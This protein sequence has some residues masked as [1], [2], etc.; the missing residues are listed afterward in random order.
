VRARAA[1]ALGGIPT[2]QARALLQGQLQDGNPPAVRA[3]ALE[4][5]GKQTLDGGE[6]AALTRFTAPEEPLTVR[7][8]AIAALAAQK[9]AH[10]EVEGTLKGF[11][12]KQA[13]GSP[14]KSLCERS[15]SSRLEENR[16]ETH[17]HGLSDPWPKRP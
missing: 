5:L 12:C 8:S 11:S 16:E 6:V 17:P 7:R 2:A 13:I 15:I 1:E 3:A 10:P 4:G 9:K 14:W